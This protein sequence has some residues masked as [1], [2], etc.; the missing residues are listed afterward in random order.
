MRRLSGSWFVVYGLE[1]SIKNDPAERILM[2]DDTILILTTDIV[3]AHL[4]NN[5]IAAAELPGLIE[6]VYGALGNLGQPV[7][8]IEEL[9]APAVSVRASVKPDAIA[10]LECG[11]KFK[12]LKRHLTSDHGLTPADYRARWRLS[13]DYPL[14]AAEYAARRSALA[15]RNGL[16]RKSEPRN[17]AVKPDGAAAKAKTPR[18]KK[19]GAV[20]G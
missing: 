6:A 2:A 15:V 18:R 11:A 12:M 3:A 16:G 1:Q 5:P 19:L 13:A 4:G 10:C 8:V 14:V 7:P 9:R 17:G 20:F